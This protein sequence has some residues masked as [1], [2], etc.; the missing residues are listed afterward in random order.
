M[1][2]KKLSDYFNLSTLP[3]SGGFQTQTST[4]ATLIKPTVAPYVAPGPIDPNNNSLGNIAQRIQ[5][6]PAGQV[7]PKLNAPA[8][9]ALPPVAPVAPVAPS[10]SPLF[11][12]GPSGGGIPG[13]TPGA[14]GATGAQVPASWMNPDGSYKTADQIATEAGNA[15]ASAHGNAD[16]GT[17]ALQQFGADGQTTEEAIAQA[18]KIG[19]TR[20]DIAVGETD[21]YKVAS[22]SGIAYTP[23]ELSAIENAYKGVY[24]PALDTALAKVQDKQAADKLKAAADAQANQPFTLG[25]DDVRYDANGNPIAVGIPSNATGA[26]GGVYTQGANPVVDAYVTGVKNQ[27]VKLTDVP[28]VYKDLVVQGISG[29]N[30]GNT[31]SKNAT[32]ALSN[33]E[34]LLSDPKALDA[35]TGYSNLNPLTSLP[36]ASEAPYRNLL[37]QLAGT[38]AVQS[39]GQLKGSGAISDFEFRILQQ[40]ASD[41]G[42]QA[43]GTSNL[44]PEALKAS[45]Q[46][47]QLKLEVGETQLTDDEL[48]HLSDQGYTPD[49]IRA[50]SQSGGFSSAGNASDSK[51][52]L[53]RPQRN[54]NPGNVKEGGS[55][56]SLAIGKDDQ[57]HLIFPD[58]KT[59]FQALTA[60]V[61]AKI[62]GNSKY[63]PA[64]PTIAQLGSVYAEDPNWAKKVASIVGV[65]VDTHAGMVPLS[66]LVKAIATQEG[67]YA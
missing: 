64:N 62:A 58:A 19:N 35:V 44:S 4:P 23:A 15:L 25:K 9:A 41:L 63:L 27:T 37:N 50:Y 12:G 49:Q 38:L 51:V 33:I 31:L 55:S 56:D 66:N 8:P 47:L 1:A 24:D 53:N 40:A 42:V 46:K 11:A 22:Q 20:N 28:D 10:S 67:F 26:A 5:I 54:N 3:A 2:T 17:L 34:A 7:V 32:D 21:P 57:G 16:V 14:T 61:S 36:G 60:D 65:P 29:A 43:N 30:G 18:R 45:L 6:N 59:G 48:Q 39:R 52:S 13:V